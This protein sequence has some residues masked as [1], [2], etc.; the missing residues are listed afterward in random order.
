MVM[1]VTM[2]VIIVLVGRLS[3]IAV[4]DGA[5]LQPAHCP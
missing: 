5:R 1:A 2:P 4:S 3:T